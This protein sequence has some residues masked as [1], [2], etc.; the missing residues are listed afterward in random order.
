MNDKLKERFEAKLAEWGFD[1]NYPSSTSYIVSAMVDA[2]NMANADRWV[3][4][5]DS[6]PELQDPVLVYMP[7]YGSP[8]IQVCWRFDA[9][10][11]ET[12]FNVHWK[13]YQKDEVTHWMSLPTPPIKSDK[14]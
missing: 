6:L 11:G 7:K 9:T 4:V 13:I 12:W 3:S 10:N 14:D 1:E 2:Y 5:E 8:N